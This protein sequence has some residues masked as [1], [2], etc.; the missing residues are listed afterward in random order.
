MSSKKAPEPAQLDIEARVIELRRAGL[1][2]SVIAQQTGFAGP[3]GAYKAYQRAAERLIRP[4]L[5]EHRDTEIDRLDRLQAAVWAKAA[6]GDLKAIDSVLRI[7]DRRIRILGLEA[8]KDINLKAEVTNYD[9]DSIDARLASIIAATNR[10]GQVDGETLPLAG[11][12]SET[13][14]VTSSDD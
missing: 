10:V 4:N 3:S 11:E 12:S 13:G 2:W 7:A 1:T 9:A 5:E 8:P 6:S 14:T